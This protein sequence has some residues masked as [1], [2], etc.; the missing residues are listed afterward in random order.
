MGTGFTSS[1]IS[2]RISRSHAGAHATQSL[3]EVVPG[4]PRT[5]HRPLRM[6]ICMA[7]DAQFPKSTRNAYLAGSFMR[8]YHLRTRTKAAR[9]KFADGVPTK[10]KFW[11]RVE[12]KGL[13]EPKRALAEQRII[14]FPRGKQTTCRVN[15]NAVEFAVLNVDSLAPGY[16]IWFP[17]L[18]VIGGLGITYRATFVKKVSV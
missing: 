7:D 6:P 18:F 16:S 5:L 12:W 1:D 14:Q 13:H 11:L 8:D 15:P 4:G 10:F 3:R 9:R 2:P 17:C